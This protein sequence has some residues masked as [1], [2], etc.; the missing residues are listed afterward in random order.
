MT[1]AVQREL[2][3]PLGQ[4]AR[5]P[6]AGFD[7]SPAAVQ[8]SPTITTMRQPFGRISREM[9]RMLLEQIDGGDFA[10]IV[11]PTELVPRESA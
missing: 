4:V 11:V 9:V 8:S 1:Q 6:V 3:R 2:A 10:A 7:D 5:L